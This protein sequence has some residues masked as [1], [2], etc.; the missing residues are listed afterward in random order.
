MTGWSTPTDST[1]GDGFDEAA[2]NKSEFLYQILSNIDVDGVPAVDQ[3]G[4]AIGDTDGDNVLEI[5]DAWGEPLYLQWQLENVTLA[6]VPMPLDNNVW[7]GGALMVGLSKEHADTTVGFPTAN[8]Y[9]KPVLPT[10]IRPFLISERLLRIDGL[11]TDYDL[12]HSF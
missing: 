3:L 7:A 4:Q 6:S 9:S 2:A 5:V 10:Q 1:A 12:T 8:F 11:P